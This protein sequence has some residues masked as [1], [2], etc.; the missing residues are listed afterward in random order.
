MTVT[1]AGMDELN[2]S[3]TSMSEKVKEIKQVISTSLEKRDLKGL[4]EISRIHA[5]DFTTMAGMRALKRMVDV[6]FL[7]HATTGKVRLYRGIFTKTENQKNYVRFLREAI[8]DEYRNEWSDILDPDEGYALVNPNQRAKYGVLLFSMPLVATEVSFAY[9][10]MVSQK[11]TGVA[12]VNIHPIVVLPIND[13]AHREKLIPTGGFDVYA[14]PKL[15]ASIPL[16]AYEEMVPLMLEAMRVTIMQ[17]REG[18]LNYSIYGP[19]QLVAVCKKT[20]V[21]PN[22]KVKGRSL[23]DIQRDYNLASITP[24][25]LAS[26][27][28]RVYQIFYKDIEQLCNVG[29]LVKRDADTLIATS[30]LM[31]VCRGEIPFTMGFQVD[32][33]A[34]GMYAGNA[35]VFSSRISVFE[36]IISKQGE[37]D[38]TN[39]SDAFKRITGLDILTMLT[40]SSSTGRDFRD[41][42]SVATSASNHEGFVPGGRLGYAQSPERLSN[43]LGR[44][45]TLFRNMMRLN[46]WLNMK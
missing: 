12:T 32:V 44:F 4:S 30:E 5:N 10:K 43:E 46:I 36:K 8:A 35:P 29:R 28:N 6:G 24:V 16:K 42:M 7:R 39:V 37:G 20:F 34:P 38:P 40:K 23:L 17:L 45:L 22:T 41:L 25:N 18:R 13:K 31:K 19:D 15:Q 21:D 1:K 26:R 27:F 3:I 11:L 2:S 9:L 14:D 33:A